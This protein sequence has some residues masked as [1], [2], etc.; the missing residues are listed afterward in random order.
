MHERHVYDVNGLLLQ[1]ANKSG[2]A[3]EA[4]ELYSAALARARLERELD[5]AAEIQRALLPEG[6][7]EGPGFDLAASSSPCRAIGGDFLD[8][9]D[10]PNGAFGFVLGDVA[11]KGPSAAL[12]AARL[13][14]KRMSTRRISP[15]IA[16]HC[17]SMEATALFAALFVILASALRT[18][19]SAQI[20]KQA[21]WE[22]TFTHVEAAAALAD[23]SE[24]GSETYEAR[25][26]QRPWSAV[27]PMPFL[28]VVRTDGAMRAQM[29]LYWKPA[30][31][32]PSQRPTGSDIV[33]RD[34]ICVRPIGIT[35]QPDW[36]EVI[37]NL[38]LD[39]CREGPL[40]PV[41]ADCEHIWI[42][43]KTNNTYREQSCNMPRP[44]TPA[45]ALLRLM[46]I[47]ADASRWR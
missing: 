2:V 36:G 10:L 26:M 45:G 44:E 21:Q 31:L 16:V 3:A 25:V 6:Q 41:C 1:L 38:A 22:I 27:A 34:G 35:K 12:L 47:A 20:P 14:G 18:T 13:Q 40:A 9:F 32:A 7:Y 4:A 24:A 33:C 15:R 37:E 19:F 5:I 28:R 30:T 46:K 17:Q 11:G 29:F 39:A 8:Y 23:L 42:K 43:T